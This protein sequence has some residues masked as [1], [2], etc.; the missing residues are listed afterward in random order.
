M[1]FP[2]RR[3]KEKPKKKLRLEWE[4]VEDDQVGTMYRAKVE[5]GWLYKH[6]RSWYSTSI[7]FVPKK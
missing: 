1:F 2:W 6:D 4:Q 5:G 3:K 7:C